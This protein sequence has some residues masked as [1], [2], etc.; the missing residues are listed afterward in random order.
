M[1]VIS[2]LAIGWCF[3]IKIWCLEFGCI[4]AAFNFPY[5][6][7]PHINLPH[8]N[9]SHNN[10]PH[11]NLSHI[12]LPHF[13]LLHNNPALFM[14]GD[15]GATELDGLTCFSCL[16][17]LISPLNDLFCDVRISSCCLF[18]NSATVIMLKLS[19]VC[20]PSPFFHLI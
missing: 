3:K 8:N 7:L 16:K 1:S 10:L 19:L 5:Y 4:F 13:N 6:N 11:I 18:W 9:F 2:N 14:N 15:N 12:N 20:S 17:L